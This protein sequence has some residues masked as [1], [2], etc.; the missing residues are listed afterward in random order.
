M[1]SSSPTPIPYTPSPTTSALPETKGSVQTKASAYNAGNPEFQFPGL[2]SDSPWNQKSLAQK[3]PA[4][5]EDISADVVVV[6]AGISGL[7]CALNLA[8]EGKSVVVL[9][10]RV[11]GAGQTGK[12]T[13]HIMTWLDD[14]YYECIS[15]HGQK[16]ATLVAQSLRSAVDMIE[17]N[18]VSENIDCEFTRLDGIL[19][20]H[21]SSAVSTLHK[22]LDAALKC[23]LSDTKLVDLGGGADVGHIK[24]ALV[25]PNN[26]EFHP[27]KYLEG[28][29]EA[30]IRHGGRIYEGTKAYNLDSDKVRTESGKTVYCEAIVLATNSPINHNLAVHAR[31]L[32]YRSYVIGVLCPRSQFKRADYWS[33]ET[34]Y[35][36]VRAE[37]WDEENYMVIIG[38][39]DHKSGCQPNYDV[40]AQLEKHA[41]ERWTGLGPV[42]LK[43]NGQVMEPADMLY[44]HG[45]D[46]LVSEPNRYIITGDSGQGMTGGTIG[47]R[48]VADL[49]LGKENP[50]ADVYSPSR[51]PPAKSLLEIAEEGAITT[52]SFAERVLPK[53]TLSYDLKPGKGAIVQK[54][55]HKV[56]LYKDEDGNEHA[57]SA[58]CPH[59]GCIV[60]WVDIDKS[61]QCPCHGSV[62]SCT[63]EL[64]NGPAKSDLKPI[65]DW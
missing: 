35:H 16:N 41:R 9:E 51:V 59:L 20:P 55:V 43:W 40:Y 8:R 62:F 37:D 7:S 47:G 39:E 31:Q 50:W 24:E 48:V 6:G 65:E 14:Y 22:E 46:P 33:T 38:G 1:L 25:F 26:G 42:V 21:S 4:L 15:M 54:G 12:T 23:G 30:V 32:P 36:Y 10:S 49:I 58:V 3:Y 53:V 44:L 27:L 18:V 45:R 60:H 2:S 64:V 19:Y 56:A 34:E 63:G 11:R 28:L 57:M 29:A 13:A 5:A 61:F 52:A 17:H